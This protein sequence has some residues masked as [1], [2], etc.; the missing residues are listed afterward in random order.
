MKMSA[1]GVAVAILVIVP[2]MG[3]G[4]IANF[5]SGTDLFV[6]SQAGTEPET[7]IVYGGVNM[8]M[9]LIAMGLFVAPQSDKWNEFGTYAACGLFGLV[10]FPLSLLGDTVTL[11][12]TMFAKRGEQSGDA[13]TTARPPNL[14][15]FWMNE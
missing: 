7:R 1:I 2:L 6:V 4:T 11:P 14:D 10:D 13:T 15:R 3:C 9:G 8:D 5:S 12:L